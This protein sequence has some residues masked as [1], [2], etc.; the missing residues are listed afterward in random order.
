MECNLVWSHTHDFKIERA[1]SASLIWNHKY[2]FRPKLLDTV[3]LPLYASCSLYATLLNQRAKEALCPARAH[4]R[5]SGVKFLDDRNAPTATWEI[6]NQ[7]CHTLHKPIYFLQEINFIYYTHFE[8]TQF[9]V[10]INI[11]LM[12]T[13]GKPVLNFDGLKKGRDLEQKMVQFG[14]KLH[15]WEPI[16]FLEWRVISKWV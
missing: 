16:R 9:F 6:T 3:Q 8:I 1:H 12:F 11:Y 7:E 2:D 5:R 14:N 10:N 13:S 4:D 15:C